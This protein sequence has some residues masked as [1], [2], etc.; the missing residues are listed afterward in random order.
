[1]KFQPDLPVGTILTYAT[2]PINFPYNIHKS[3]Y[4][5]QSNNYSITRIIVKNGE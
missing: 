1:M 5:P 2:I 4:L 3:I